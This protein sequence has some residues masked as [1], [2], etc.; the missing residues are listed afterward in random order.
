MMGDTI[1]YSIECDVC[2]SVCEVVADENEQQPAF[3]PMCGS[4]IEEE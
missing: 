2:E 1:T 3:C 4:P